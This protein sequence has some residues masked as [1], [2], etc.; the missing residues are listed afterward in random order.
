M[1]AGAAVDEMVELLCANL[2][3]D[4][5]AALNTSISA[6]GLSL[7]Q[8]QGLMKV[9]TLCSLRLTCVHAS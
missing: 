8:Q 5:L 1:L 7:K 4:D 6:E 2:Q 9:H 3:K